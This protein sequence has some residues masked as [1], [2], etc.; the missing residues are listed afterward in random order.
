MKPDAPEFVPFH[1]KFQSPGP[2]RKAS[3]KWAAKIAKEERK[4]AA[5]LEKKVAR[6]SSKTSDCSEGGMYSLQPSEVTLI[7]NRDDC[8]CK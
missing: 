3:V 7:E 6:R 8:L 2:V 4:M 1:V 5:G